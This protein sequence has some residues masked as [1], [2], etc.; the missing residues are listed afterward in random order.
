[1]PIVPKLTMKEKRLRAMVPRLRLKIQRLM[2]RELIDR[3]PEFRATA[4]EVVELCNFPRACGDPACARAQTCARD[5]ECY[6][7]AH[8]TFGKV[9]PIMQEALAR[10]NSRA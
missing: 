10:N 7:V 3:D 4:R 1:M 2:V 8:R 5:L 6:V 9:L